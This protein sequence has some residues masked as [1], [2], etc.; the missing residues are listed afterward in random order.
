MIKP[1]HLF[2]LF[3]CLF[4]VLSGCAHDP[5]LSK[6]Q[7]K[8]DLSKESIA[9]LS[10]RLSN[11]N[12]PS[13]QLTL[14]GVFI[15]PESETCQAR[16]Y[17]HKA[18]DAYRSE[19]GMFND[20]L[21]SI[22][23]KEGKYNMHTLFTKYS[24]FLIHATALAPLDL[25]VEIKPNSVI[26]LG[27]INVV[28]RKKKSDQEKRAALFPL[29]DAA[30]AGYSTG[31]FDVVVEDRFD[32]DMQSLISEYPGLQTVNVEKSILPQWIRPEN[33]ITK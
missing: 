8:I 4:F 19:K 16:P 14:N 13:K 17:W 18:N 11:Q 33:R 3:F 1:R 5:A 27:H 31:T 30:V 32:E 22:S 21:M 29:I 7:N 26:Y 2:F 6:G 25:N 15:C 28:L 12:K 9:L 24:A 10:V 23:L 20:Y